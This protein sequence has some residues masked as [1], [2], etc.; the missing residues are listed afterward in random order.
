[1]AVTNARGSLNE[2][3]MIRRNNN[4]IYI[5]LKSFYIKGFL[6]KIQI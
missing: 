4:N 6:S 5:R 2:P 3:K 1:M